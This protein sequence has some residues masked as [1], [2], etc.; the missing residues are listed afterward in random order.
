MQLSVNSYPDLFMGIHSGMLA[1]KGLP[2][3]KT[4]ILDWVVR[5]EKLATTSKM[6]APPGLATPT[7]YGNWI[8]YFLEV[9]N[10]K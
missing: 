7:H 10:Q 9:P 6:Y 5:A 3:K 1:G 8:N 2:N 4:S